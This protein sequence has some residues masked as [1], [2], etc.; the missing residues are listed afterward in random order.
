MEMSQQ[1]KFWIRYSQCAT[2]WKYCTGVIDQK[3]CVIP[4][5]TFFSAQSKAKGARSKQ[6]KKQKKKEVKDVPSI[7]KL[8][9]PLV[10]ICGRSKAFHIP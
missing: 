1:I 3:K 6:K 7:N 10:I 5:P 9:I 2:P 4:R 8:S